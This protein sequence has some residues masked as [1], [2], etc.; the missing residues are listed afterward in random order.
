MGM[1]I[2][3]TAQLDEISNCYDFKECCFIEENMMEMLDNLG[4]KYSS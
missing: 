4:D 1:T 3:E 2:L